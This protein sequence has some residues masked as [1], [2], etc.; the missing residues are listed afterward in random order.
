[1]SGAGWD[2][3]IDDINS[4]NNSKADRANMSRYHI[5]VCLLLESRRC[6]RQKRRLETP[7]RQPENV[8]LVP[9][10]RVTHLFHTD[11]VN[12]LKDVKASAAQAVEE[13]R[14]TLDAEFKQSFKTDVSGSSYASKLKEE[15]DREVLLIDK[16]YS[17][18]KDELIELLVGVVTSVRV[19]VS[20][21][22]A[23]SL[24]ALHS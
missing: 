13:F 22:Y 5:L 8:R 23:D 1:M 15:T 3:M 12:K 21:D 10:I 17:L 9:H 4:T 18:K 24:R 11:R 2:E 19:E 20:S 6:S 16:S 14:K 7:S